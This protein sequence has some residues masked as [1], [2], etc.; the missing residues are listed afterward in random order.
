MPGPAAPAATPGLGVPGNP[1][2]VDPFAAKALPNNGGAPTP[3]GSGQ[4]LIVTSNAARNTTA[5]N[6]TK[7]NQITA[8]P[9]T[10]NTTTSADMKDTPPVSSSPAITINNS[11]GSTTLAQDQAKAANQGKP[12]YDV[13]GN[14]LPGAGAG[15]TDATGNP[16]STTGDPY[17]AAVAGITDPG[18]AAQYKT[19]L[20]S[21]DQQ[22]TAAQQNLASAQALSAN[23]P[24][25]TAAIAAIQAKYEQQI[26]LMQDKNKQ[27][28]GRANTSVAAF[29]G[30]GTMSQD[31]LSDQQSR[32]D[33][34]ISDLQAQE[35]DAITKARIA[36]QTQDFKALNAAMTAYDTANKGKLTALNDLLTATNKQV[37][38]QQAQQ[39]IDMAAAK[40]AVTLDVTRSTNNAN[41][42]AKNILDSGMTDPQQISDYIAG[43]ADQYGITNP[44]ILANAV[45]KARQTL[46]KSDTST[47]NTL[48]TITNRDTGTQIK[49]QN[50]NTSSQRANTGTIKKNSTFNASTGISKVTPQMEKIKGA[51]GYI[52]P[53]KWVAARDTWMSLGGT[54]AS[55]KSNFIQYL[56]P[57]SY[58]KAG[59]KAPAA[60]TASTYTTN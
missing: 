21:L 5:N 35:Q 6:V 48:D 14:P 29:G 32:A 26:Q 10:L 55:F 17:D 36:Y 39:K 13:L 43:L 53:A 60:S 9:P 51:D 33:A 56:N 50:A 20:Q 4:A 38:Q 49:Q 3:P 16:T 8:P 1:T 23:D 31:F 27:L 24:A 34:R 2:Y 28:I 54:A 40:Q 42:I 19:S 11:P 46:L 44:D 18:L 47:A 30:L 37:T 15:T 7:L 12:G 59:Y 52:D 25:A 57:A 41:A 58:T 22:V 45:E